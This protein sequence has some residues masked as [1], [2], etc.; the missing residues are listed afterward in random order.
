MRF[1]LEWTGSLH[2]CV[3]HRERGSVL[4]ESTLA[5]LSGC[6]DRTLL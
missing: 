4:A 3:W 1:V 6:G 2:V 5:R